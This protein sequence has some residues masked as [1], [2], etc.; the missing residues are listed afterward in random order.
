M[1]RGPL[2]EV[3]SFAGDVMN[4]LA[5]RPVYRGRKK[6]MM[7]D[8]WDTAEVVRCIRRDD[9]LSVSILGAGLSA[10]EIKY[11][12]MRL[13]PEDCGA[14]EHRVQWDHVADQVA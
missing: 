2:V 5:L 11:R 14:D 12:F 7:T 13:W 1:R 3:D 6:D 8:N 9:V 4:S 10:N